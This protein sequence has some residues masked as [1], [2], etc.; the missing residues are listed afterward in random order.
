MFKGRTIEAKKALYKSI[1]DNLASN[2]GID[3]D[4]ITIVLIEPPLENWGIRGGK[5]A[6]EVKLGFNITV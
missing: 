4:D 2:P 5:P 3:G 1:N 6:S